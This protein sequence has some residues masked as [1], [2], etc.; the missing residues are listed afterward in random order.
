MGKYLKAIGILELNIGGITTD[1]K[2][3]MGDN[4]KMA[5][6]VTGYQK[7]KDQS[8]LL[9]EMNDFAY[10]LIVRSDSKLIDEDK[11]ELQ[12]AIEINQMQ[13]MEDL[14]VAFKWASKEDLDKAK[15]KQGDVIKN[16]MKAEN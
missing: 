4:R 11:E 10:E 5:S 15:E 2:P 8:R 6:I 3:E 13:V 16:L 1:V 14:M 7:H 9:K 12:L